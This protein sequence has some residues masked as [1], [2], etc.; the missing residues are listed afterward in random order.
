MTALLTAVLLAASDAEPLPPLEEPNLY[1]SEH[2]IEVA[3]GFIGGV[4]DLSRSDFVFI[5]G[6]PSAQALADPFSAG[7]YNSVLVSGVA[8]E[9]RYVAHHLR[10]TVGVQKPFA[11]FRLSDAVASD[12]VSTRQLSLWDFRFG[13]G[14]EYAFRYVAPFADVVGDMQLVDAAMVVDGQ[15]TTFR[16]WAFGFSVRAG[17]RFH[18]GQYL[19][20][21]PCG[22]VGLGGAQRFGASLQTGWVIPT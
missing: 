21:A 8:G 14:T 4:R 15:S 22:E 3:F 20:I 5:E 16:A 12:S 19:Y 13:I 18:V 7:P 17:L 11:A 9:L 2:H 1:L 10:F 6:A